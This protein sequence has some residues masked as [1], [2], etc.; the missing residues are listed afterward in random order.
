MN[1]GDEKSEKYRHNSTFDN[2][3]NNHEHIQDQFTH[4]KY[5]PNGFIFIE[6][7]GEGGFSTVFKAYCKATG[8]IVAIKYVHTS[9]KNANNE[10]EE[11]YLQIMRSELKLM[12]KIS[13]NQHNNDYFIKYYNIF[14]SENCDY[15]IS[16]ECGITSLRDILKIRHYTESETIYIFKKILESLNFVHL[17]KI[18]HGDIKPA[19]IVLFYNNDKKNNRF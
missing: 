7:I 19:N 17:Q 13:L 4:K 2:S 9:Q 16:M 12:N 5:D 11:G 18:Y 3:I 14:Y 8:K 6:K 10:E 1:V 15:V